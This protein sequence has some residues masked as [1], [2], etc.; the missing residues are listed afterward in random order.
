MKIGIEVQR[1]FRARKFGI[2]ASALELIKTL[3]V[4]EP[5]HEYVVF[6]KDDVDRSCLTPSDKLSIRRVS[7]KLFLDFE[8]IFLPIAVAREKV[9]LLHCTGNTAPYFSPVPVI[10]TLHDIIFMD[11]IPQQDPFYQRFGN[12][13]RRKI[14]PLVTPRSKV[15]ITVSHYE[16]DRIIK[17][18]NVNPD[19]VHVVYNGINEGRFNVKYDHDAGEVIRRRYG[20]PEN[21]ILFLGNLSVR[22]N[23]ER[24]IEAYV[25]YAAGAS[26]P[27]ALVA[28]G[29]PQNYIM[30]RLRSL[31]Y[32]Y[33]PKQFVTPGYIAEADLPWLY[34]LSRMFLFPSLTEGFG[35]PIIEA[36]AC[37]TPVITSNVSCM[38]EIAGNAALLT[39]PFNPKALAGAIDSL[40]REAGLRSILTAAGLQNAKRFSWKHTASSVL[41]LYSVALRSVKK[42]EKVPR[43]PR[44]K[45]VLA[46]RD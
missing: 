18:L 45:H 31:G 35:M 2:E 28:P 22:K 37:G 27:L 6:V 8:Q 24:L 40:A 39:D 1:L 30:Q 11:P 38:P 15:V 4:V 33:N 32:A 12:Q 42:R 23:P 10:Q 21:Y 29:L 3:Q 20:L 25:R 13:Y 36:M 9:D 26:S 46:A 34:R 19:N 7:G 14:V 41:E 5:A 17:R 44:A 16:K 43:L